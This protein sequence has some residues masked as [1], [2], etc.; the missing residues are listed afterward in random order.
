MKENPIFCQNKLDTLTDNK[1]LYSGHWSFYNK[2]CRGPRASKH[3]Q[4]K[5]IM[6]RLGPKNWWWVAQLMLFNAERLDWECQ[7]KSAYCI[8]VDVVCPYSWI[9]L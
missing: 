2:V 4:K 5:L 8:L 3:N 7:I 6:S 1:A 9:C